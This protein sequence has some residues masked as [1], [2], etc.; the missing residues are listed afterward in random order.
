[1][2]RD[3]PIIAIGY[4]YNTQKVLY[5]ITTRRDQKSSIKY[6][7]KHPDLFDNVVIFIV[8][9]HLAMYKFFDS[10]NEFN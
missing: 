3:R 9:C 7:Y 8:A 10:V 2:T 4:K 6:L 5:F 1:M